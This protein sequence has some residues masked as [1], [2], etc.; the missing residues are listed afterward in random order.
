MYQDIIRRLTIKHKI[1]FLCDLLFV[2]NFLLI[3]QVCCWRRDSYDTKCFSICPGASILVEKA[4][5]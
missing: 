5:I 4:S 1:G 3:V 2:S